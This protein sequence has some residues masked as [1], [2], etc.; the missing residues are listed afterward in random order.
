MI[1]LR[2]YGTVTDKKCPQLNCEGHM[3]ISFHRR[4]IEEGRL[5]ICDSCSYEV[6]FHDESKQTDK[7]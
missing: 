4:W 6:F 5:E 3:M 2:K 7:C 1:E